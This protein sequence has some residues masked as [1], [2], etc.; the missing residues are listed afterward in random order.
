MSL[1]RANRLVWMLVGLL[2]AI[3]V[4][5]MLRNNLCNVAALRRMLC[6]S[7]Q[8]L[9]FLDLSPQVCVADTCSAGSIYPLHVLYIYNSISIDEARRAADSV[10]RRYPARQDLL[11]VLLGQKL[12][13]R[14]K[15]ANACALWQ[16]RADTQALA[17]GWAALKQKNWVALISALTCLQS[18]K[19]DRT[20]LVIA[21][22]DPLVSIGRSDIA[23]SAL[24]ALLEH[25]RNTADWGVPYHTVRQLGLVYQSV[26]EWSQA[27]CAYREAREY[28][29][30]SPDPGVREKLIE[31]INGHMSSALF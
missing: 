3:Q 26:G 22:A 10:A 9:A 23:I 31:G 18:S 15:Y 20:A 4:V 5:P 28:G 12:W 25:T 19:I 17:A 8:G 21:N 27:Y 13:A 24:Q 6:E 7:R 14:G 2:A 1:V 30:R 11:E 29:A 16:G